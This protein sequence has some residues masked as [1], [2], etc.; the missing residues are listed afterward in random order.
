MKPEELERSFSEG[1]VIVE[2]GQELRELYVVRSGNVVL[3]G[4]DSSAK[5]LLGPGSIFGELGAVHGGNS[6]YRAEADDDVCV[7]VLEPDTLNQLVKES[8]EFSARL[9]RHLAEELSAALS[10]NE[11]GRDASDLR[12]AYEKLVPV[13]F[14]SSEGNE[15]PYPV[16][17]NLKD[18]SEAA[19]LSALEAYFCIQNMLESR[20]LRL[21]DDQ[22]AIVDADQLRE[23]GG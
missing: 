4:E 15:S 3:D 6:P 11:V 7:L 16:A 17:G 13:I 19:Q 23:L 21:V 1:Q 18:L 9:I 14:K 5:R 2:R 12:Y 10:N 22:L 20:I 8:P